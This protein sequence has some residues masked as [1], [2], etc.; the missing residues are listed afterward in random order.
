MPNFE[1]M[2]LGSENTKLAPKCWSECLA[3]SRVLNR[4]KG[5]FI[6]YYLTCCL[7]WNWYFAADDF[8]SPEYFPGKFW[9][10]AGELC[11]TSK[12]R[13]VCLLHRKEMQRRG[14]KWGWSLWSCQI[15]KMEGNTGS[16]A[17]GLSFAVK[18]PDICSG[19]KYLYYAVKYPLDFT[20]S[21]S[22]EL[23][24]LWLCG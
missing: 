11:S 8:S 18:L 22:A 2:T 19:F 20:V 1:S 5:C 3:G 7:T 6:L 13:D 4:W 16:C 21:V 10:A 14:I 17:K 9:H 24:D 12:G 15:K 23:Q